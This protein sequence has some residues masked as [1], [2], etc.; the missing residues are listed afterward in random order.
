MNTH[1]N[2]NMV[3]T[4]PFDRVYYECVAKLYMAGAKATLILQS[5][6][7][8]ARWFQDFS[9]PFLLKESARQ[10]LNKIALAIE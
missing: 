2:Q 4:Q 5:K 8:R 3:D 6:I 7:A 10:M 9:G 1:T